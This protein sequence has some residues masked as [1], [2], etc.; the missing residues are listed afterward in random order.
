MGLNTRFINA[1]NRTIELAGT[2]LRIRYYDPIFD[3]TY[4]ESQDI[5]KSGADVWT[6]GVI[7]SLNTRQG[8]ADS[9]L[10]QQGKL[11][12][13][14]KK[15]YLAGS[16]ALTGSS[17]MIDIQLGSPSG[18]LFTTIPEGAISQEV[19]GAPVYQKVFIRRLTG[20]L[21]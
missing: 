7:F 19:E 8:S 3:D 1:L 4:D 17:Q 20:S 5:I 6:S 15:V 13:S 2:Q 21:I 18:D 9:V 12:D 16:I 10:V 11:I 14:D